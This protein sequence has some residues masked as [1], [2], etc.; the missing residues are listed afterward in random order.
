[1]NREQAFLW[2]SIYKS[3]V[4]DRSCTIYHG[5]KLMRHTMKLRKAVIEGRL[6]L[7]QI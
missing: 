6:G 4:D 2:A 3:K 7:D 5:V 1:M